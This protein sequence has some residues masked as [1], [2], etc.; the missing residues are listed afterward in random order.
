MKYTRALL[1]SIVFGVMSSL[2]TTAMASG[3]GG[4][5][6]L[7]STNT[8]ITSAEKKQLTALYNAKMNYYNA[9][10]VNNS[11]SAYKNI[12]WNSIKDLWASEGMLYAGSGGAQTIS[13]F[14]SLLNAQL[15]GI[16]SLISRISGSSASSVVPFLQKMQ[17]YT[18]QQLDVI[19]F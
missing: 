13:Q 16:A 18:Q 10:Y 17:D 4:L 19:G 15:Q 8:P 11:L 3:L 12:G 6:H 1:V 7:V 9:K 2:C 14:Y 5:A